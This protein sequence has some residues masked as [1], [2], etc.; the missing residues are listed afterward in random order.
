MV[1]AG[2]ETAGKR[3]GR[4]HEIAATLRREL[5]GR[6]AFAQEITPEE[7]A[8][9]Y[10]DSRIV[11]NDGGAKHLP[12]TM[13]VFETVGAGALLLT[14]DLPGTDLLFDRGGHYVALSDGDVAA[15]VVD[16][17]A[18]AASAG[19]ATAGR[20]RARGR[21]TYDHR[22]DELLA[23]AAATDGS[24]PRPAPPAR[25]TLGALVDRDAEVQEIAVFG[26]VDPMGLDDRV[27]RPAH[28]T[29][30][31]PRSVDAVVIGEGP[32]DLTDD[33]TAYLTG[34]VAA[35]RG[36]VYATES[37]LDAVRAALA[38]VHPDAVVTVSEG[39]LRADIGG[40]G[41]RVPPAR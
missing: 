5:P 26:A 32:A 6:T 7:M 12:I 40:L 34:A 8:A 35:A 17:L 9:L 33:L 10:E 37:R 27:V 24:A 13:R 16:L 38:E 41:Y 21:H 25:S 39:Q 14:E 3:Y 30:M 1:G 20:E 11:V 29:P 23:I 22:V 28:V 18:S 2:T 15:Q 19:I 31:R 4:R 36:F